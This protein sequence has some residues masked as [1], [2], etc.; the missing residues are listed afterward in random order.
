MILAK[1]IAEKRFDPMKVNISILFMT[2]FISYVCGLVSSFFY[3]ST[4]ISNTLIT[5][6]LTGIFIAFS[7][8][9]ESQLPVFIK[10]V[11]WIGVVSFPVFLVHQPLM[12]WIGNDFTG[13]TKAVTEISVILL[14]F[15]AGWLIDKSVNKAMDSNPEIK[16]KLLSPLV[17]LSIAVQIILNVIYFITGNDLIYKADVVVFLINL[18]L[19]PYCLFFTIKIKNI[20]LC[21]V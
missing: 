19:I 4:L 10:A 18:L 17:I 11:K 1:L 15:P 21:L 20:Q 12:L 14:A 9:I 2:G 16:N 3:P 7:R 8:F 13:I 5:L 6:G